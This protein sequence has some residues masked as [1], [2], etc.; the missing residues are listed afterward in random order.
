MAIESKKPVQSSPSGPERLVAGTHELQDVPE[1]ATLRPKTLGEYVGQESVKRHLSI[2]VESAKA[3]RATLEHVLLYGP[4]GLGKTT[5]A[6]ILARE[7]GASLKTTSGPAVEK[8]ADLVSLLTGL[9]EGDVLFIDEI[10]RLKPQAEE[11]LYS[12]MEDYAIDIMVGSGTGASSVR[13]DIPKFTL[14]GATT[15]LSKLTG[16][17]R[18]RFGNVLKLDFYELS[19]LIAIVQRSMRILGLPHADAAIA[20]TVAKKSRGTPR[21]ANRFVKILRD[22]SVV[23][24]GVSTV[25]GCEEVFRFLGIDAMG[26][27][28]LDRK[29]LSTLA[30]KFAGGPVGLNTL[31]SIVGEEEETVEDVVEPYLLKTGFLERTPRGRRL[32]AAG[33][34]WMRVS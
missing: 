30:F 23:G 10:H 12:A 21:I 22:Y 9:A 27:D 6:S 13:M 19:E 34:E 25:E 29:L 32:T 4:P 1:E 20:E 26:L 33:E 5:L 17:L 24:K 15:R 14:I 16:P 3:R 18:D 8:P 31:A 11:I 2:A 7:M 28:A